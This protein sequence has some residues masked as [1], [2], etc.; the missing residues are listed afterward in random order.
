MITQREL[1]PKAWAMAWIALLLAGVAAAQRPAKHIKHT[2]KPVAQLDVTIIPSSESA[3]ESPEEV[4]PVKEHAAP[5]IF[6]EIIVMGLPVPGVL[7]R[8]DRNGSSCMTDKNGQFELEVPHD[9]SGTLTPMKHA[10]AFDPPC[11]EYH[12]VRRDIDERLDH[13][14]NFAEDTQEEPCQ[15]EL[16][17]GVAFPMPSIPPAWGRLGVTPMVI[18]VNARAGQTLHASVSVQNMGN[19]SPNIKTALA[20]LQQEH[21]GAWRPTAMSPSNPRSCA[22]WLVLDR[23]SERCLTLPT[24][25]TITLPVEIQVPEDAQGFY[26]A[27][28]LVE[29]H[30][31]PGKSSGF[32]CSLV[33]PVLVQVESNKAVTDVHIEDIELLVPFASK[34]VTQPRVR[35][36]VMNQG[37]TLSRFN[38][39]VSAATASDTAP[40]ESEQIMA[41]EDRWIMPSTRLVL[42]TDY[43]G[44]H[45]AQQPLTLGGSLKIIQE[46]TF[47]KSLSG[48]CDKAMSSASN[49]CKFTLDP[50]RTLAM[51]DYTD[52][53]N[54]RVEQCPDLGH[55]FYTY[56]GQC[57]MGMAANFSATVQTAIQACSLAQGMWTASAI[58]SDIREPTHILL[59]VTGKDVAVGKLAQA[60]NVAVAKLGV[61]LIPKIGLWPAVTCSPDPAR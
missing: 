30:E 52:M 18:S 24:M 21:S 36:T 35:M 15:D 27:A 44:P 10:W 28:I 19:H 11:R 26:S 59:T 46:Q 4:T 53:T 32:S 42:E 40:S 14:S 1:S 45:P 55:P 47:T 56:R 25:D 34:K 22:P 6:G 49:N 17:D 39:S 20:D 16:S 8:T 12:R 61:S 23:E 33:V 29:P 51:V 3:S 50:A 38:A 31:A 7:I 43:V 58:P 2:Y 54:L 60:D 57:H 48:T 9:W 5:K 37:A 13:D 41:F